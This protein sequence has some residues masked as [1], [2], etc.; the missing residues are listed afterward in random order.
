V[1]SIPVLLKDEARQLDEAAFTE[2]DEAQADAVITGP[3]PTS[4]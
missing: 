2:L 3:R 4:S 1:D